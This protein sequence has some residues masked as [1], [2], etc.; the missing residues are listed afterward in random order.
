M[1]KPNGIE[2]HKKNRIMKDRL[3][4]LLMAIPFILLIFI[5]SYIPLFGWVYAF[6]DYKPGI[7]L[8]RTPFVGLKF[9]NIAFFGI[10]GFLNSLLNSFAISLLG[11]LCSPLPV[12][13]AILLNEVKNTKFKKFVQ[14]TTTLPYFISWVIVFSL[15]FNIFSINGALNNVLISLNVIST[16]NPTNILG[17]EGAT[18]FFQTALSLWKSTGWNAIIYVASISGIDNELYDAANVDGAGRWEIIKNVTL[19]GII[20]T[21]IVLLLLSISNIVNN[22]LEQYL[23]FYN[24]LVADRIEVLDYFVYRIGILGNDYALATAVGIAKTFLSLTLLLIVNVIS[25]KT[26]GEYI[27]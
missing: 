24:P 18:W 21:F 11:L 26:R 19:P 10:S 5:F 9:F 20:P 16:D 14:T 13:L 23:V 15:F 22:G 12:V 17:N 8:A 25:K 27:V 6:F 3:I 1:I 2:M 4:L 7:P